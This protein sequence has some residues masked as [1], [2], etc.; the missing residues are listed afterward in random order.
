MDQTDRP[1]AISYG[2]ASIIL[3]F[4]KYQKLIG[5]EY[6]WHTC[7]CFNNSLKIYSVNKC[8]VMEWF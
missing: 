2:L 3:I 7:I 6:N 1:L 4:L 5:P 8:K